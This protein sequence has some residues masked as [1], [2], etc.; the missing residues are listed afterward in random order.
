M[1]RVPLGLRVGLAHHQQHLVQ[2]V[3]D[4]RAPPLA[5]VEHVV[6]PVALD[7]QL[8]VGCVGRRHLRLRHRVR[9]A[10]LA[11]QQ[12]LQPALLLR[13]RAELRQHF[14]IAPVRRRAVERLERPR[15]PAH[16]LRQRRELQI[17]QTRAP[18]RVLRRQEPI[19]D[20]RLARL[21]LQLL[22]Q[23]RLHPMVVL[24]LREA[25]ILRLIRIDVLVHE[26]FQL[27]LQLQHF[28]GVIEVHGRLS[29]SS[30]VLLRRC[31]RLHAPAH[32]T[33]ARQTQTTGVR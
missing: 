14:H 23:R 9:R 33:P 18:G 13:R 32:Q 8:H 6:V 26:A 7:L 10:N 21:G 4:V 27:R 12:R 11:R 28:R 15:R 29:P 1:L 16:H 20:P 3:H 17:R 25:V 22:H 30:P 19:P 24:I 31:R 2:R 5:T